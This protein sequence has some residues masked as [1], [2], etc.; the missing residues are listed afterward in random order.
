[1]ET[2]GS[3]SAVRSEIC[4]DHDIREFVMLFR[5]VEENLSER[6]AKQTALNTCKVMA[7]AVRGMNLDEAT[8]N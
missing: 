5:S 3:M 2:V 8:S 4:T 6:V 7:Q 1:M